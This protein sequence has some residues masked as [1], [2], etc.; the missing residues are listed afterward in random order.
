MKKERI[1]ENCRKVFDTM[2]SR[3]YDD[4]G[5]Y[6]ESLWLTDIVP[7]LDENANAPTWAEKAAW[8]I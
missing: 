1:E 7:I 4:D 5:N 2:V 8:Y 3:F 6:N